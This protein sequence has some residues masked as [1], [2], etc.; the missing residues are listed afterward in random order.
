M[1]APDAELANVFIIQR[2]P[3][4]PH[5]D[6]WLRSS[7]E[8]QIW[9]FPMEQDVRL[10]GVSGSERWHYPDDDP[11]MRVGG[12]ITELLQAANALVDQAAPFVQ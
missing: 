3:N 12:R 6:V 5:V 10:L 7:M 1:T 11:A 8:P 2:Y 4:R 9:I